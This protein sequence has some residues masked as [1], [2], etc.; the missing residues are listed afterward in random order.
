MISIS[1]GDLISMAEEQSPAA[2]VAFLSIGKIDEA[3]NAEYAKI[4]FT[5]LNKKNIANPRIQ[6]TFHDISKQN[7]A[8]NNALVSHLFPD[9]PKTEQSSNNENTPKLRQQ[10]MKSSTCS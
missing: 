4:L 5:A 8:W 7:F 2:H 10:Q 9:P 6:L 1:A 3:S